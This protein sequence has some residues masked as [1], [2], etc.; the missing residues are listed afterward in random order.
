MTFFK[1][2]ITESQFVDFLLEMRSMVEEEVIKFFK[3]DFK[4]GGNENK[5]CYEAMIFSL[6]VTTISSP[7]NSSKI[8]DLLHD[9][10]CENLNFDEN[11]KQLF[12]EEIDRRYQNYYE[13]Y[14]IWLGDPS[15]GGPVFGSVVVE[16][17]HNQ[18]SNFSVKEGHYKPPL[19]AM[20]NLQACALFA[21][22]FKAV[23]QSIG[24]LKKSYKIDHIMRYAKT[25]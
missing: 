7:P 8:R 13:A 1:K 20:Q 5:L 3:N 22:L 14:N 15:V 18:N 19:G 12:F 24:A 17:I 10:H 4:Y 11:T 9:K 16:I 6:W 2:N 25:T 21:S 23:K